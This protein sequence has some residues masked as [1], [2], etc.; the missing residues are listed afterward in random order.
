MELAFLGD[1]ENDLRKHLHQFDAA[2]TTCA[3]VKAKLN[4]LVA[5]IEAKGNETVALLPQLEAMLAAKACPVA[6]ALLLIM[7]ICSIRS[8]A[9][10]WSSCARNGPRTSRAPVRS[11]TTLR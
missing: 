11:T 5:L 9:R 3:A 10:R 7:M 1:C 6:F 8:T 2:W 4:N